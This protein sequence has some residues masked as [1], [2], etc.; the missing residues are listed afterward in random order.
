MDTWSDAWLDCLVKHPIFDL[1][2][3]EKQRSDIIKNRQTCQDNNVVGFVLQHHTRVI[4][5]R[6][7]DLLVAIGS[8]IRALNL[9]SFKDAW[10]EASEQACSHNTALLDSWMNAVPY[11]VL[12]TPEI[13]FVIESITPNKNGRLLAV[14]GQSSLVIVCLPRQ[15][16]SDLSDTMTVKRID[17]RT[18]LIGSQ[19]YD[20]SKHEVLKVEWHPLSETRTHIVVLGNDNTLRI[21]DV[22]ADIDEPEQS[23]DLSP[24]IQTSNEPKV[25]FSLDED[26][27][28]EDAVTFSLGGSS[29]NTSGW[30]PFTV[31]YAL[32][33]GHIYSLCPVIPYR[34]MVRRSHLDNLACISDAKYEQAKSSTVEEHKV[35]SHLFKLQ[36]L[37]I[38]T[39]FESAKIAHGLDSDG[40]LVMS[41]KHHSLHPV[42]RQGPFM[43]NHTDILANGAEPSDILY[44]NADPVHILALSLNNGTV[45]NYILGSEIDAQ[46]QMSVKNPTKTWEKELANLLLGSEYLPK[47][48]LYETIQLVKSKTAPLFQSM[49]LMADPLYQDTYFVYHATGVHAIAMRPWLES[50]QQLSS[51][52]EDGDAT[53]AKTKL[54]N[55]LKE[56]KSSDVRL[57]VDSA[58]FQNGFMPMIGL[59]LVTDM[60]LSYSL[61]TIT[62]DYHLVTRD[63]NM[64]RDIPE[65]QASQ[66]AVKA[67]LKNI[68]TEDDSISGYQAV[69]PLP[70]FQP[71]PHGS[72][73]IVVNEET[74]RFF[75]ESTEKIRS[76][77]RILKQAASKMDVRLTMQ[78]KEFKRQVKVLRELYYKLQESNSEEAKQAQQQKL[79]E[80]TKRHA[81]L[82]L[83]IDA[84][85]R[86]LMKAYQPDLSNEEKDWIDSLEKLSK[87]VSGDSG[88]VARINMLQSQLNQLEAQRTKVYKPK[89]NNMNP[90]QLQGILRTLNEQSTTIKQ[91]TERM[92]KLDTKLQTT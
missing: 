65:S 49:S 20:K 32:R 64:R 59:A 31:F 79:K 15:G 74:L 92:D 62:T 11:K 73:E 77:A 56:K 50:L 61:L 70:A 46:W 14:T 51:V 4:T 37:W 18:L 60:Y 78:E 9:T 44:V 35:L 16:F 2:D 17:C 26:D 42:Q 36:S 28:S 52:Y 19:Y 75:A 39:L 83:R 72:K 24:A 91:V 21:F 8:E 90:A 23:F 12:N 71:P 68:G 47:A 27:S 41:D 3:A 53:Q 87:K 57:L 66:N 5:L 58:P 29:K 55:W 7:N 69:L 81:Q 22:S 40:L 34:S 88:Y 6:D 89:I 38:N 54:V 85:L 30:E 33:S 45:H 13:D 80:I 76:E 43:I 84:Q 67:Q 10:I 86:D 25:G 48:S 1:N 82:R 63:L